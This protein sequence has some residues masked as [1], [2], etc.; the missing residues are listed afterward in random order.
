[1]QATA[2]RSSGAW[3]WLLQRLTAVLLLGL[4]GIHIVVLHFVRPE[5]DITFASVHVR[6]A[7]LMYMVVDYGLLAVVLYH[8]LNGVRNVLLD[9]T[10]G[11]RAQKG[12]S[13]TLLLV[14]LLAFGYGAWALT[15][16]ITGAAQP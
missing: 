3:A 12:I 5:G 14:G 16:F 15:P 7:T 9:F 2:G 10:F 13:T 6:L 8:G 4:L 11:Q 1:M